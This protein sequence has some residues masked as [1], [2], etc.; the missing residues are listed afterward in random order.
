MTCN[1]DRMI[2][3]LPGM[4]CCFDP[5][6]NAGVIIRLLGSMPVFHHGKRGVN[7]LVYSRVELQSV[8]K[9]VFM[10]WLSAMIGWW[11]EMILL[12][13]FEYAMLKLG[14]KKRKGEGKR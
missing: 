7:M 10:P 12:T 9:S 5:E 2:G 14:W 3:A 13:K 4:Q 8:C 6:C 11:R 1:V